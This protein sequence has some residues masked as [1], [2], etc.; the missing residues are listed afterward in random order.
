ME[1][2]RDS[3]TKAKTNQDRS[4]TNQFCL[5]ANGYAGI[6]VY[7][8]IFYCYVYSNAHSDNDAYR[9]YADS[10]PDS[11]RYHTARDRDIAGR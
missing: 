3:D 7:C 8:H 1:S 6:H 5:H 9:C 2:N 11:N 10:S 4:C